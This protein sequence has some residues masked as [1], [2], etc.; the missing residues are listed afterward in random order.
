MT[1]HHRHHGEQQSGELE[2]VQLSRKVQE[3]VIDRSD[4]EKSCVLDKKSRK[5][6]RN[7]CLLEFITIWN[8][9]RP[10]VKWQTYSM[11]EFYLSIIYSICPRQRQSRGGGRFSPAFVCLFV[12]LFFVRTTHV[13]NRCMQDHQIR[14]ANVPRWVLETHLCW[15]DKVKGQGCQSQKQ[16]R[17]GSLIS[18]ECWFLWFICIFLVFRFRCV[19]RL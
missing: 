19:K 9:A 13:K 15:G 6:Q 16:C 3:F 10:V 12:C 17:R 14:H 5:G 7:V 18:C 2:E 1:Q 4:G 11:A 8:W